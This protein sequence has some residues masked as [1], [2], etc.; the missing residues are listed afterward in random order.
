M[1]D[2]INHVP[3]GIF[4]SNLILRHRTWWVLCCRIK[5]EAKIP[6]GTWFINSPKCKLAPEKSLLPFLAYIFFSLLTHHKTW[7]FFLW[8]A[9]YFLFKCLVLEILNKNFK[10]IFDFW[11]FFKLYLKTDL[12]SNSTL[13]S[14]VEIYLFCINSYVKI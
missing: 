14:Q 6:A 2:F 10:H 11:W 3:I 4:T 9:S 7:T 8:R 13:L 12:A 1:G 5:F